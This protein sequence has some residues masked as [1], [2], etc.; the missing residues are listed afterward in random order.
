[1][2]NVSFLL[3]RMLRHC[4]EIASDIQGLT[5]G[6]FGLDGKTQRAVYMSLHQIGELVGR[7]PEA[8]RARHPEIPWRGI[9]Q[10][11]NII[12]HEYIRIDEEVVWETASQSIPDFKAMIS[13]CV[14]A[15]QD[16]GE[17]DLYEKDIQAD[18][19]G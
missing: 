14:Q 15:I 9:R 5:A 7:L 10:M 13:A 1:M 18:I 2:T 6:A 12:S 11:R 4:D 19:N 17:P 3:E 8:F 16:G